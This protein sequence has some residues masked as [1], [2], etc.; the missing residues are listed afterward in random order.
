MAGF[1]IR[2]DY[3]YQGHDRW[4]WWVWLDAEPSD[5]A[6]VE[7]VTWKLHETFPQP[8]VE[9]TNRA[10]NF[11]LE[12]MGWGTFALRADVQLLDGVKVE[13]RH[14]LELAYPESAQH[15][16]R[17][18]RSDQPKVFLSYAAEDARIAAR[19]R[20]QLR[21]GGYSVTGQQ[22]LKP[23]LPWAVALRDMLRT[24]DAFVMVTTDFVCYSMR[25]ELEEARKAKLPVV[26]LLKRG[27]K[28]DPLLSSEQV[29]EFGTKDL[30]RTIADALLRVK[31]TP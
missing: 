30:E 24:S 31:I 4:R 7:R 8:V 20:E 3:E 12:R 25:S 13:L 6:R 9:V 10:E 23:G 1:Q 17:R 14:M 29:L 26:I 11:R 5:L 16:R 28:L 2:Q 18:T 22:D 21:S 19:V 27:V 15:E